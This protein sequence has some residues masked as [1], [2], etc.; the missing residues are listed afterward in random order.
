VSVRA[1]RGLARGRYRLV[2]T[3][4]VHGHR[5]TVRQRVHIA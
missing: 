2:V 3:Y 5:T 4:T 1:P